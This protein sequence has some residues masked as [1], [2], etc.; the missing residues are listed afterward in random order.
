MSAKNPKYVDPAGLGYRPCV[1]IMLINAQGLVWIGCRADTKNEAE[2]RG[3]WW[4]MP[5]G[6]I[7]ANEDPRKAALRELFEET[8][9]RSAEVIAEHP[10]WINYDLP[11][12]LV[13]KAWGG[14]YRGQTQKWFAMRFL[15]ARQRSQ[16]HA[17]RWP[18]YRVRRLALGPGWRRD[19]RDRAVQAGG[20][21]GRAEGFCRPRQSGAADPRSGFVSSSGRGHPRPVT[22]AS[23]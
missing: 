20:L 21:R 17:G 13:G 19:G 10:D 2:G 4:Q 5:Q 15:G 11:R 8:G 18:H 9:I 1:G 7:D 22:P 16:H 6:G 23:S 3:A 14:R 12:D